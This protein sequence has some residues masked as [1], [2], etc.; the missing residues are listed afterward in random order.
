MVCLQLATVAWFPSA[1]EWE[2]QYEVARAFVG[3]SVL[4]EESNSGT[5]ISLNTLDIGRK[6]FNE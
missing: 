6:I 1:C 2:G 4:Q 5:C 3:P